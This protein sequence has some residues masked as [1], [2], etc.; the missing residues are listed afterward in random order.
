MQVSMAG[1]NLRLRAVRNGRRILR[2]RLHVNIQRHRLRAL[3]G[4]RL[5]EQNDHRIRRRSFESQQSS[6]KEGIRGT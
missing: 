2:I 5:S 3:S 4:H 6:G 1:N